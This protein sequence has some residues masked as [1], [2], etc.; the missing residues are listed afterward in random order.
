[1]NWDSRKLAPA[2]VLTPSKR[3]LSDQTVLEGAGGSSD[4]PL[5]LRRAGKHL[6]YPQFP[7]GAGELGSA[8]GL[9]WTRGPEGGDEHAVA[10]AVQGQGDAV[11][12]DQ[13]ADQLKVAAGVFI[14]P[15]ARRQDLAGG[16]ICP[17]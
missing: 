11:L 1:M 14:G 3:S 5:G 10:I 8:H 4:S 7:H 15:E 12:P 13:F 17:R 2:I 16:V 6:P 9:T